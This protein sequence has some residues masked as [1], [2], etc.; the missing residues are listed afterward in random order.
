MNISK[1]SKLSILN[2]YRIITALLIG[3]SF[4]P[5]HDQIHPNRQQPIF[6][7]SG[8]VRESSVLQSKVYL[9][10]IIGS[11]V[12][13]ASC[14]VFP[15]DNVWNTAVDELPVHAKSA[16]Y[17]QNIGYSKSFHSEFGS[18]LWQGGPIG[19]PYVVV[20]PSQPKVPI[21]YVEYGSESDPGPY[22][23]PSN[24]PVEGGSGSNGDRHVLVIESGKC[25]L[26]ELYHA[27][28]QSNGSWNAGS[29]AIFD[30]TQ[31]GPLRPAG[32]TSA[33]AAGLP[34]FPGLARYDEVA[35]GEIRHAL[36]FTASCTQ[37][38]YIWPA[39]HM[40][41]DC[42]NKFPP[43][44]QRFRLKASFNITTA[45]AQTRVILRAMQK[46][47]IIL[48]DNGAPWY[49]TG[50]PDEHWDNDQLHWLDDNLYGYDMEAVDTSSLMIDQN[51]GQARQP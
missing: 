36:R 46:Y 5:I 41:G 48:A 23:V 22:P 31:N 21:H 26:Y 29:G 16:E 11:P 34:I 20:P 1:M 42:D 2:P 47:G 8:L 12:T 30:L 4:L 28:P 25:I 14:P 43:M 51:S 10:V 15:S 3:I 49:I 13:I 38:N 24:A 39:R 19:I 44:G 45:P 33:D 17:I 7:I 50:A 9:P 40:S 37:G 18:G 35:V 6:P 32:W 27:H